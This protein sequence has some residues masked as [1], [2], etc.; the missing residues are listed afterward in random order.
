MNMRLKRFKPAAANEEYRRLAEYAATRELELKPMLEPFTEATD[1]YGRLLSRICLVV[2]ERAPVS[3][4]DAVVRDLMADVFDFLY[5]SHTFLKKGKTLVA[6]PLAR[7]AYESLS[8]L[9]LCVADINAAEQW[10]RGKKIDNKDVRK[11]LDTHPMGE[12]AEKLRE[13]YKFFCELTHPNR[14]MIAYRGLGEGNQYV[15]G[16]IELPNLVEL[17]DFCMKH[18]EL[19]FWLCPTVAY[20]YREQVFSRD[21][22]F[23]DAHNNA[24]EHA[25]KVFEWL[26]EERNRLLEEW[27]NDKTVVKPKFV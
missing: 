22:T 7:R 12:P 1:K 8:L 23:H 26:A 17:A 20:F 19:W 21:Q 5:E 10:A 2:G 11:A 18:L 27:K 25:Q 13:L 4:Q 9:H 16:S 6:F 14:E 15:F 3:V 24:R